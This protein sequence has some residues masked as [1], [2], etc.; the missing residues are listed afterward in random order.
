M[1]VAAVFI[2]VGLMVLGGRVRDGLEYA[3]DELSYRMDRI[4]DLLEQEEDE[5]E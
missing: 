2:M 3:A 1:V 5:G 4:I